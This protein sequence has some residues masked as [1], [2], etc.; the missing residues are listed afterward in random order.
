MKVHIGIL[1]SSGFNVPCD[2]VE[3]LVLMQNYILQGTGNHGLPADK[4]IDRVQVTFS[5]AFPPDVARNEVC[6]LFLDKD[7]GEYLLFLDADM[8][9]PPDAAHRLVRHGLKLVTG[10]YVT[11]RP[12]FFTVAMVKTGEGATAY[13]SVSKV[14]GQRLRGLLPIDA[15]GAGVLLVHRQVLLDIR[16]LVG[17]DDWFRYQ[18]GEAGLRT[19]SE[20]MWFFERAKEAGHQAWLDADVK[21]D[22]IAQFR[23]NQDW[24]KPFSEALSRMAG[25]SAA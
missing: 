7:D 18:D 20:D 8:T 21:C 17:G 24:H 4:Q 5:H 11:R 9:H 3:S 15:A 22:H 16:K 2:F 14:H 12:P 13:D 19:R 25:G 1:F 23:V 10:S 6:R